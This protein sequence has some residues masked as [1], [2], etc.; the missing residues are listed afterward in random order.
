MFGFELS[1]VLR[2]IPCQRHECSTQKRTTPLF[3]PP[4]LVHVSLMRDYNKGSW[5]LRDWGCNS[6]CLNMYSH[7]YLCLLNSHSSIYK[8]QHPSTNSPLLF[9]FKPHQ[10]Q[11]SI[12]PLL[13]KNHTSNRIPSTNSTITKE[14]IPFHS[15]PLSRPTAATMAE[16]NFPNSFFFNIY[17]EEE[18]DLSHSAAHEQVDP[19]ILRERA[20][21]DET[22][23]EEAPAR[24]EGEDHPETSL[25]SPRMAPSTT[26]TESPEPTQ[27]TMPQ[28]RLMQVWTRN[29]PAPHDDPPTANPRDES[30]Q[31][32]SDSS[33]L[34]P[35]EVW[36]SSSDSGSKSDPDR[37]PGDVD[38]AGDGGGASNPV[39][40]GPRDAADAAGGGELVP[41]RSTS[42]QRYMAERGKDV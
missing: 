6:N 13:F 4:K 16:S 33:T 29:T 42:R 28:F 5:L 26:Q 24:Q 18:D 19:S 32:S 3:D 15:I 27:S 30:P 14:T 1:F 31:S 17:N 22:A 38:A 36:D 10:Q 8:H 25:A 34:S 23:T 39:R 12:F 40:G 9:F 41:A 11:N 37:E 7:R 21:E 2:S 20:I 35:D